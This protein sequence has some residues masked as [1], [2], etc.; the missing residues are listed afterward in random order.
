MCLIKIISKTILVL[1]IFLFVT[2][3]YAYSL[4]V[5][6]ETNSDKE[7]NSFY[8]SKYDSKDISFNLNTSYQKQSTRLEDPYIKIDL[9]IL[10]AKQNIDFVVSTKEFYFTNNLNTNVYLKIIPNNYQ[11]QT[12][13]VALTFSLYDEFNNL[14]DTQK[15]YFYFIANNS[16]EVFLTETGTKPDFL[17]YT[18][19]NNYLL[20]KDSNESFIVDV[21]FYLSFYDNYKYHLI[22][23]V[24]DEL[25]LKIT[26]ISEKT[27]RLE[28][29]LKEIDAIEH[30]RYTINCS[31]KDKYESHAL[32]PISVIID[33]DNIIFEEERVLE[34]KKFTGF[35]HIPDFGD[36]NLKT[37]L[38][39]VIIILIFLAIL[40]KK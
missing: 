27:N 14:L 12:T 10:D 20:F 19:S 1:F 36:L 23:D 7:L 2:N 25:N 4:N 17:G 26:P 37:I 39:V 13:R 16:E 33:I 38:I 35:L 3:I 9:E 28:V 34:K 40:S 5:V 31:A 30:N 29:S 8:I 11:N 6:Q 15:Q 22:C 24:P 18:I 32:R 21:D